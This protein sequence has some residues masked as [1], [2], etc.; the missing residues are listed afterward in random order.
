MSFVNSPSL[1][2]LDP[3]VPGVNIA[4]HSTPTPLLFQGK[5]YIFYADNQMPGGICYTHTTINS[6][7]TFTP[8]V[9][10]RHTSTNMN[11]ANRTGPAA[12]AYGNL[13]YVF[14]N[15]V[16][17]DGT[18]YTT[19]DGTNN[20]W[21]QP[22]SILQLI[23]GGSTF[24][25]STSPSAIVYKDR[26]Y[27]YWIG[28]GVEGGLPCAEYDG[29]TW[30]RSHTPNLGIVSAAGT[31]AS[32]IIFN[33]SFYIF[34]NGVNNDGTW[35]ARFSSGT[36]LPATSVK[37][38]IAVQGF[39]PGTSPSAA[40]WGDR[41]CLMWKG[42]GGEGLFFTPTD[43]QHWTPQRLAIVIPGTALVEGTTGVLVVHRYRPYLLVTKQ[44]DR[45]LW[46]GFGVTYTLDD[47]LDLP[48]ANAQ[49]LGSDITNG[50]FFSIYSFDPTKYEVFAKKFGTSWAMPHPPNLGQLLNLFGDN[51]T[52]TVTTP[53]ALVYYAMSTAVLLRP[54]DYTISVT[55]DAS[56]QSFV[57]SF[58][59]NLLK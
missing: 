20:N 54:N 41:L 32:I 49:A 37:S 16:G 31:S 55:T 12:V 19:N 39:Y 34:Y 56:T 22:K 30:Y 42:S 8:I 48:Q 13:I 46:A 44:F 28:G 3:L 36:W 35:F 27:L 51:D 58:T 40:I 26:I 24:D 5:M 23:G 38:L 47:T 6:P 43:G 52:S 53:T 50:T 21:T 59:D 33:N 45:N 57:V 11:V 10:I 17:D 29:Q 14:F 7:G 18:W 2:P 4:E 9:N 15:G 1:I 25:G